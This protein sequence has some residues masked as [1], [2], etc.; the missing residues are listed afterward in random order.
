[1]SILKSLSNIPGWCTKRKIVVIESDDWGSLR[2]PTGHGLKQ[3]QDLGLPLGNKDGIRFNKYDDLASSD[4]LASLFEVLE[5]VKDSKG[6]SAVLTPL[7]LV[8]NPDFQ[9]ILEDVDD[10]HTSYRQ[11]EA[12]I[13]LAQAGLENFSSEE[14]EESALNET[15]D[16]LDEKKKLNY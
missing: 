1:M 11:E 3:M 5:S 13:E 14:V 4:D 7:C 10:D 8:A 15:Y 9:K 16:L 2:S 12:R 6:H